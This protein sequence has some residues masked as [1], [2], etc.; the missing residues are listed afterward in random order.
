[1]MRDEKPSVMYTEAHRKETENMTLSLAH[2]D[3][4]HD[5]TAHTLTNKTTHFAVSFELDL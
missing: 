1:M 2:L 3:W 4:W 5:K